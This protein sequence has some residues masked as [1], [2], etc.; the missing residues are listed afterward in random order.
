MGGI[1]LLRQFN[2]YCANKEHYTF[3]EREEIREQFKIELKQSINGNRN[4]DF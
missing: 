3:E 2:M 4:D 1:E